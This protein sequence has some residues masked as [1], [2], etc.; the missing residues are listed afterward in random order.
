MRFYRRFGDNRRR[1]EELQPE[2]RL[3]RLLQDDSYLC[4]E[5]CVRPGFTRGPVICSHGSAGIEELSTDTSSF[6]GRRKCSD[7]VDDAYGKLKRPLF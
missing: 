2:F 4:D 6:E 3:I 7:E 5:F 1:D